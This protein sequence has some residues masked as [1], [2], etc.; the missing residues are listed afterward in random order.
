MVAV[1]DGY[2]YTTTVVYKP[3]ASHKNG[4]PPFVR[5]DK[6]TNDILKK[7]SWTRV[8]VSKNVFVFSSLPP[9]LV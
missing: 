7:K 1:C 8:E 9:V 5:K 4:I 2:T 6:T 3:D